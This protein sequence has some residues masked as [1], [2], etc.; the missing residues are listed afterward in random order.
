MA[1]YE[2]MISDLGKNAMD[3]AREFAKGNY[4]RSI[5]PGKNQLKQELDQTIAKNVKISSNLLDDKIQ[6][7]A[8]SIL[9]GVGIPDAEVQK[10][11]SG[12]HAKT[13]EKDI[14][15]LANDIAKHS[16][17]VD[18]VVNK[19]TSKA[20][21]IV[22]DGLNPDNL[23]LGLLD[24]AMKYPQA[25]FSNPDKKITQNRIA[26]AAGAYVGITVGGRFLSGGN[27]TSD[28][29]GKKDIAGIPFI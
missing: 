13:Y 14:S 21:T 23:Q 9:N 24:K 19:M 22:D 16:K 11:A 5:Y 15:N 20:K 3:F 25:Y 27:L 2:K 10:M 29:Y 6:M 8:K 18:G 17:N 12:I 1:S 7:T 26:T 4:A 28:S